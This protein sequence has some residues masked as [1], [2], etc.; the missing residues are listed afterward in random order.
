MD[1]TILYIAVFIASIGL[2]LVI[3]WI[4]EVMQNKRSLR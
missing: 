2:Y 1:K 3:S 4:T